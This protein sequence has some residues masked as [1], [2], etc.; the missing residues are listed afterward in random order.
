VGI[1][2]IF[3]RFIEQTE[4]H[5]RSLPLSGGA[6]A[7]LPLPKLFLLEGEGGVGGMAASLSDPGT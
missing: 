7:P 2:V 5:R 3:G 4:L 1:A 6:A